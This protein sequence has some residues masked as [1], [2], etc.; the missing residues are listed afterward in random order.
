MFRTNNSN[1]DESIS[2]ALAQGEIETAL[3][4]VHTVKGVA[5][6]IGAIALQQATT[7]LE[8]VIRAGEPFTMELDRFTNCLHE[9][10]NAIACLEKPPNTTPTDKTTDKTTIDPEI[11]PE[12]N[13]EIVNSLITRMAEL[14]EVDMIAAIDCLGTLKTHLNGNYSNSMDSLDK[15]MESFNTDDAENILQQLKHNLKMLKH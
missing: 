6:S 4:L 8:V 15:A 10:T 7:C 12:I 13:T 5:G 11:D 14:L 2:S 9:V 1:V 3:R